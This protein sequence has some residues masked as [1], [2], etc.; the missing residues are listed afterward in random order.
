ML[1]TPGP[2]PSSLAQPPAAL[3]LQAP[4][5]HSFQPFPARA[6][7]VPSLTSFSGWS[8]LPID[9]PPVPHSALGNV[10]LCHS[11]GFPSEF[12]CQ[13]Q[14]TSILSV[15]SHGGLLEFISQRKGRIWSLEMRV[16]CGRAG[17]VE[18]S[19]ERRRGSGGQFVR[20]GVSVCAWTCWW[21]LGPVSLELGA[22]CL[23]DV[24]GCSQSTPAVGGALGPVPQEVQRRLWAGPEVCG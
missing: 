16:G 13:L 11:I 20:G 4:L 19:G 7:S 5:S 8:P 12:E 10:L 14:G 21:A 23:G 2:L 18:A 15:C 22:A 24:P 6:A 9:S 17:E 1:R 3:L